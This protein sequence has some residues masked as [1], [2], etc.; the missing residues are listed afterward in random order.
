MDVTKEDMTQEYLEERFEEGNN[1][2]GDFQIK[3]AAD[4]GSTENDRT[5]AYSIRQGIRYKY[6]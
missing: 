5:A 2:D 1:M 6:R 3:L 4:G